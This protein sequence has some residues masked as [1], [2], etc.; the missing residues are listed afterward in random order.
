MGKETKMGKVINCKDLFDSI[1][2]KKD[3][4]AIIAEIFLLDISD[5]CKMKLAEKLSE[6]ENGIDF[7][8]ELMEDD[9]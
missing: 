5:E 4:Y 7:L 9:A 2:Q 1:Y 6:D 3:Q 8:A